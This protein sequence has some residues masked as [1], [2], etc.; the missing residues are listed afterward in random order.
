MVGGNSMAIDGIG[1]RT[2]GDSS[3]AGGKVSSMPMSWDHK[4]PANIYN[5]DNPNRSLNN[6][7][8]V[9]NSLSNR[10]GNNSLNNRVMNLGKLDSSRELK[11]D[12]IEAVS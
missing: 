5:H 11:K 10:N 7:S 9:N 12:K 3:L 6:N 2:V 8:N 4:H 1:N